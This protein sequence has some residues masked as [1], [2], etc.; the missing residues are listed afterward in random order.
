MLK[1]SSPIFAV[2]DVPQT[3]GFYRDVL[4]FRGDWLWGEPPTFGG[5]AMGEI[6]VMFARQPEIA[7]HVEGHQHHFFCDQVDELYQKHL[8]LKAP[9]VEPIENKPWSIREYTV[10]DLNGYHLR[11]SGP[12]KY[13][14][15]PT[16]LSTMPDYI[17]I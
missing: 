3:V 6:G 12:L 8:E 4:G 15:P 5:C 17:R 11:F 14:K 1:R 10:R 9:I 13:D 16:A 2:T 7:A